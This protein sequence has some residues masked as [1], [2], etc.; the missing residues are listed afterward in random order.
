MTIR[1]ILREEI[2]KMMILDENISSL[3]QFGV[4][5]NTLINRMNTSIDPTKLDKYLN[6]FFNEFNI[7]VA[8]TIHAINRCVKANNINEISLRD[9]GL[10]IPSAMGGNFANDVRSGYRWTQRQLGGNSGTK[11]KPKYDPNTIQSIKLSECMKRLQT[12]EREYN[13]KNRKY[14]IDGIT[15]NTIRPVFQTLDSLRQTYNSM[16][17]ANP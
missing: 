4:N 3:E 16:A 9:F 8:Q 2:H 1:E 6:K 7:F 15:N 13:S 5:L 10:E 12:W 11:F 14:N 17:N